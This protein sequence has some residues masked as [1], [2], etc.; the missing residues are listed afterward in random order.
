MTIKEFYRIN[1]LRF[2]VL[3]LIN[4]GFYCLL[5]ITTLIS[6]LL[7]T[8]IQMGNFKNFLIA[9]LYSFLCVISDYLMQGL[10]N[11]LLS[12]Q[13]EQ[14]NIAIRAKTVSHF[15]ADQ[16]DHA[17][18]QV[19]N[20]LTNDI[21]QSQQNYITPFFS[22]I[23][24]VVIIVSTIILLVSLHWSLLVTISIMVLISLILPKLLEKP[25][26]NSMIQVSKT[27][28]KYLDCLEKWLNGLAEIQRYFSG[29]K[30]FKVTSKAAKNLED[31]NVKQNGVMQ[32]L[33]V[34][35][36]L[37]SAIFSLILFSLVGYLFQQKLVV[38]G[39]ITGVG[40]CQS[41]LR[42]GIQFIVTS[43]GKMKG[44]ETLNKEIAKTATPVEK[45][46]TTK[47]VRPVAISTHNLNLQF[48]NGER[49]QFP[50][51]NIEQG[52]KI[53]LT[54]DSGAGKSTLFKLILEQ[55]KPSSGQIIFKDKDGS[56]I[57]PDMSKIG[58][59]P[60]DPVLFPVT[61]ADNMTMF[62]DKLKS[63]LPQLVEKV[64][65]AGDIAKFDDGLEQ[66]IDLNKLNISG[67]QRQKIVLVRALVHQSEIFLIDE[68]TSAID[69][70]ATMQILREITS[71]SAT[72]IFIA[73][74]F[75][76]QMKEMFDREIHLT[77]T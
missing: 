7:T 32:L 67:G 77:K 2:I 49:L 53:L 48:P 15:Y 30:L 50:D 10:S 21:V 43:Y 72:V 58:Y 8:A 33:T 28:Q 34:I 46:Q 66:K 60:Q 39:A 45:V 69:Q 29:A 74:S 20:R 57:N 26:Q 59:I 14:Y 5:I 75:N 63:A 17:V 25:L 11:Y 37:V 16:K 55:I 68:G 70:Q 27:N 62:S 38:F 12:R 71:S 13:E 22:L 3:L 47:K 4:I 41:Y 51:I 24:G 76:D 1:P 6:M 23:G 56:R 65:L 19:Q 73:H 18:A 9:I 42:Q 40:N 52:E 44:S 36:G 31:A 54:G 64:Q 35:N 61:I